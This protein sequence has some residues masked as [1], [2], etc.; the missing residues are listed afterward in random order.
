MSAAK[1]LRSVS[2]SRQAP[3]EQVRAFVDKDGAANISRRGWCNSRARVPVAS[4]DPTGACRKMGYGD[5]F[6]GP[7][8]AQFCFKLAPWSGRFP[9]YRRGAPGPALS[10]GRRNIR[11]TRSCN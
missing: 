7:R 9:P 1:A 10:T 6:L 11:R 5:L 8:S 3:P 4:F 2:R